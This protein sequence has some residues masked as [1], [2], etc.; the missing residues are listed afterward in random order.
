MRNA[1][2]DKSVGNSSGNLYA[3]FFIRFNYVESNFSKMFSKNL[4]NYSK[5]FQNIMFMIV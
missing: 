4:P 2:L 5:K 3:I 1:F